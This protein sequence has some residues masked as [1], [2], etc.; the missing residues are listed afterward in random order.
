MKSYKCSTYLA[1]QSPGD[2]T[3]LPCAP[4]S[5]PAYITVPCLTVPPAQLFQANTNILIAKEQYGSKYF[6]MVFFHSIY[7][8]LSRQ[9]L[10]LEYIKHTNPSAQRL[11]D[12]ELVPRPVTL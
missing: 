3:L 9:L 7:Q 10:F 8:P 2:L 5:N 11:K 12:G 1:T 6:I 4:D